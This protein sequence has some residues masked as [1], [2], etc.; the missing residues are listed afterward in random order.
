MDND[1]ITCLSPRLAYMSKIKARSLLPLYGSGREFS[2]AGPPTCS[3][4]VS[5]PL[6]VSNPNQFFSSISCLGH[7]VLSEQSISNQYRTEIQT[8]F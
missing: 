1:Y 3:L 2:A 7:G 6:K 8:S 5:N 4:S